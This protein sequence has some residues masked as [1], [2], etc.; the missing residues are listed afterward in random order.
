[1]AEDRGNQTA[2]GLFVY[3]AEQKTYE[4]GNIRLGGQPGAQPTALIGSIF[5]HGH[6]VFTDEDRDQFDT[7]AAE[8]LIREQEDYSQRTGNPCL[9][10]VVGAT[11]EAIVR[12][13]EYI[14]GVTDMPPADRRHHVRCAHGRAGVRGQ[15]GTGRPD[16]LQFDPAGNRR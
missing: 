16:C 4:V 3:G 14:A 7:S 9:L 10:D 8:K 15:G 1:M 11:P 13:L 6:E 2:S 12:H 5:Y